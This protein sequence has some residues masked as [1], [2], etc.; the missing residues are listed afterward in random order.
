MNVTKL[1]LYSSVFLFLHEE[2]I[3]DA[4]AFGLLLVH[5]FSHFGQTPRYFLFQNCRQVGIPEAQG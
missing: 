5:T 4:L 2:F 3:D 1:N